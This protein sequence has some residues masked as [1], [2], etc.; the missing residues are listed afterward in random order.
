MV[1]RG[2]IVLVPAGALV[3]PVLSD[4]Q[5]A[6]DVIGLF[7]EL[8]AK[9]QTDVEGDVTVHQPG[10]R[11]VGDEGEDEVAVR[12]QHGH[13]APRRVLVVE[14]LG[15]VVDARVGAEDVKVVAV[16]VD[17]VRL[18]RGLGLQGLDDPVA[19]G[20]GVGQAD[21]VHAGRE[22]G[23]VVEHVLQRGV[24]PGDVDGVEVQVP[25]DLR[26][27]GGVLNDGEADV[28]VRGLRD[29]VVVRHVELDVRDEALVRVVAVGGTGGCV[30]TCG[31]GGCRRRGAGITENGE[32]VLVQ[33][34]AATG[35]GN[36]VEPVAVD[37]LVSLDDNVVALADCQKQPIRDERLDGDKVCSHHRE[38]VSVE[39]DFE[40]VVCRSVD[41]AE[42]VLFAFGQGS[43]AVLTDRAIDLDVGAVDEDVVARGWATDDGMLDE[44]RNLESRSV[45]PIGDWEGAE[46]DV[47]VRC[48]RTID[49]DGTDYTVR[50]LVGIVT[51]KPCRAE[52]CAQKGV[53]ASL[54][55][56]KRTLG[57]TI[58]AVHLV[59][60]PLSYAVPVDAGAVGGEAVLHP[61]LQGVTPFCPDRW[62]RILVVDRVDDPGDPI[63][64][65]GSVCDLEIIILSVASI[66]PCTVVVG[67][68]AE[69]I[70]PALT[71]ERPIRALSVS[72][73]GSRS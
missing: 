20:V 54:S 5:L 1:L 39:A 22:V 62:P 43:A 13:V 61:D 38:A 11:I 37:G 15:V 42:F 68:D 47:V 33:V 49:D 66:R 18:G 25:L 51:M 73:L 60:V 71:G 46:I 19:P 28:E 32:G 23:V 64:G 6:T 17:R 72:F 44:R 2:S 57:Y 16:Q 31:V 12:R 45:I 58:G 65:H 53:C 56:R 63:G 26:L 24:A 35:L 8:G 40:V 14:G 55:W 10:A 69:T 34:V 67:G 29:G 59:R 21:Q 50:V 70:P 36:D 48:G 3:V 27:L 30:G 41:E 7:Q 9:T 52:L 4:G